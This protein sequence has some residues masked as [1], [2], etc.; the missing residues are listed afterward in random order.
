MTHLEIKKNRMKL[1]RF[2]FVYALGLTSVFLLAC[3]VGGPLREDI[4]AQG[5]KM[6]PVPSHWESQR[7]EAFGAHKELQFYK[8]SKS[9]ANIFVNSVCE[10]YQ[11]SKLKDLTEQLK[12][13][14]SNVEVTFTQEK[15]LDGRASLW[16]RIRGRFDGVSVES[17]FVVVRK[18]SCL[19][20]FTLTSSH[21]I[22][23]QD[24]KDFENWVQ[25]F[26]YR[27]D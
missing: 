25:G 9:G 18:N 16:T 4:S 3:S 6:G 27:G 21:Q 24:Y 5:Y 7:A 11:E 23:D 8:N 22:S 13:P 14:F 2:Q 1:M 12:A 26:E 10:R 17:F 20:D 19:F 15:I